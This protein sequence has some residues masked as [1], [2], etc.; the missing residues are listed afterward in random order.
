M[1]K[2]LIAKE[3]IAIHA[4]KDKVWDELTNPKKVKEYLFGTEVVTDWKRG[5]EIIFQGEYEGQAYEDKGV[6][7]EIKENEL[8]QYTLW[9][10]F[11]ELEDIP[12]NYSLV[13]YKLS[14]LN[15]ETVLEITQQGFADE[16]AK[17][18]AQINWRSALMQIKQLAEE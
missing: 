16:E 7:D 6:I 15:N 1:D 13:T 11:S 2:K 3:S 14:T 12:E 10:N 4:S 18:H 17:K 8:L 5:S 9:S